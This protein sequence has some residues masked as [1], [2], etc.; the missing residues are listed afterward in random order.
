MKNALLLI[1]TFSIIFLI[2]LNVRKTQIINGIHNETSIKIEQEKEK[3]Q[4]LQ[5]NLLKLLGN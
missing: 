4:L 2:V 1:V 5:Q 3:Q